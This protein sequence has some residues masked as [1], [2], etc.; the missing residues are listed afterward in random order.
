MF[1]YLHEY[2]FGIKFEIYLKH[3]EEN[4]FCLQQKYVFK[5]RI[6]LNDAYWFDELLFIDIVG[7]DVR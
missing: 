2:F 6:Y 1:R 4:K 5:R 7:N 3:D